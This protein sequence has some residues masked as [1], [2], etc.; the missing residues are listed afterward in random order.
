MGNGNRCVMKVDKISEDYAWKVFGFI[1]EWMNGTFGICTLDSAL[2]S[3]FEGF[4][5]RRK[6]S[7]R[8][9]SCFGDVEW[10]VEEL[11]DGYIGWVQVGEWYCDTGV[12]KTEPCARGMIRSFLENL[13]SQIDSA[14]EETH[15][16]L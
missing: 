14:I 16:K 11:E 9:M 13:R 4:L 3:D 5:N 10:N 15:D 6:D 7:P 12:Q 8:V 1:N 2:K